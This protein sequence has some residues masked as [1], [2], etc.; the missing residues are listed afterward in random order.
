[1]DPQQACHEIISLDK[2]IRFA[3]MANS[4]GAATYH[5]YRPDITPMLSL[6]ETNK[7]MLQAVIREGMRTTL[8]GR[9][10]ECVYVFA[11]YKKVKRITIPLRPPTVKDGSHGIVMISLELAADHQDILDNKVLPFLGKIKLDL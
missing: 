9:L 5:E 7:S 10:G 1:L 8:E 3:G 4:T 6:D 11:L 2:H